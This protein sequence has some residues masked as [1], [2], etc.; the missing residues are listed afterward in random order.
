MRLKNI[1]RLLI[2]TDPGLDDAMALIYLL[3]KLPDSTRIDIFCVGGNN[4][5]IVSFK[6][7][8]SLVANVNRSGLTIW[9]T[10]SIAQ[11][12]DP[13]T[14][15][16]GINFLGLPDKYCQ[17][18]K[19]FPQDRIDISEKCDIIILASCTIP[20][21]MNIDPVYIDDIII[22]G[23]C[24]LQPNY[25][26]LEFNQAMDPLSFYNFIK[27]Y[28]DKLRVVTVDSCRNAKYDLFSLNYGIFLDKGSI[29]YE[30]Y[31]RYS[32]YA[33]K[34]KSKSCIPYDLVAAFALLNNE[35]ITYR[36]RSLI[37][38]ND[39]KPLCMVDSDLQS[40]EEFWDCI[41]GI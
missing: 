39:I 11:K 29:E 10:D 5:P 21:M 14:D 15:V 23:G 7:A 22:M 35:R 31:D 28:M 37:G 12:S 26:G 41:L 6:N 33:L 38:I 17:F 8:C 4:S 1:N 32:K 36:N 3:K 25:N 9:S 20:Y 27:K 24:E 13:L 16:H 40:S 34:R 18:T 19:S 30:C 2:F